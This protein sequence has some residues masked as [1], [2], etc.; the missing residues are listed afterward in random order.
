M[1]LRNILY[2]DS[3]RTLPVQAG[4]TLFYDAVSGT[5]I[6]N[7]PDTEITH[8][9]LSGLTTTDAGHTQF[10]MLTGRAGGQ[11]VQGGTD[12]SDFLDLESTAHATKG[13]V[14]VKDNFVAFTN[15]SYGAG[16]SGSDLGDPT[17]YFRDI[18]TKGEAK[19]L[20]LENYLLAGIPASSAA[21]VGRVVF[22][23][24]KNKAYVD[25]GAAFVPIGNKNKFLS[26]IVFNGVEL[27]KDIDVSANIE[28]ARNAVKQLFD[29]TNN[30]ELLFVKI[31]S[32][33]ISNVRI[34]TNIALPAGSYR[35]I[36]L[37]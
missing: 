21:N 11:T 23:T 14:R 30:F 10:V 22:I 31:E 8:S 33:S 4:D 28:D 36:V 17:H 19:G 12:A 26:D 24:D 1:T 16:W 15:A 34:T 5:W 9:E 6:A 18:Y 25:T 35:L 20:R 3:A 27:T 29:N 32:T 13:S 2:R 37:E 7:H